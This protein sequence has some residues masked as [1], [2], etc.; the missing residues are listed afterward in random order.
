MNTMKRSRLS[1][2]TLA[3]AFSW[4]ATAPA[5]AGVSYRAVTETSGSGHANKIVVSGKAEGS[6]ARI[7]FAEASG[8]P[9]FKPGSFMVTENAG[10]P[11]F[12]C[13][14]GQKICSEMSAKAMTQ[15]IGAAMES[16]KGMMTMEVTD[17]KVEKLI[18]EPG[19]SM[20]G[21]PT[22]HVRYHTSYTMTLSVM[23]HTTTTSNDTLQ[24]LWLAGDL[25]DLGLNLWLKKE[26][27][28]TGN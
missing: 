13:D 14:P 20:L 12:L 15:T 3:L 23:G 2:A 7:E 25:G 6:K 1:G 28:R 27:V 21:I 22:R 17:P 24:D 4:L 11:L 9:M 26:P 8:S 5:W 18:D 19:P 16:M 10:E